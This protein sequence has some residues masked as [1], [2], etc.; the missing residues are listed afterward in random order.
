M[1]VIDTTKLPILVS[2]DSYQAWKEA[3]QTYLCLQG[4]WKIVASIN[5]RLLLIITM[6][7]MTIAVTELLTA[8]ST[9]TAVTVASV[10]AE[11]IKKNKK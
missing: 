3:V 5:T 7:V 6:L 11:V 4:V 8:P 9:N 10:A 2:T 1:L